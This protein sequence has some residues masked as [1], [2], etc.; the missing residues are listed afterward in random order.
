LGN[1]VGCGEIKD[2]TAI[3]LLVEVEVEVIQRDLR[4]TE[5]GVFSPTLQ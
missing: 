5:L 2:K 1:E 4:I 3:H